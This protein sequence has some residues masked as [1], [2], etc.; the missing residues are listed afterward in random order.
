MQPLLTFR[1]TINS[2]M[3]KEG[4]ERGR[5]EKRKKG[6]GREVGKNGEGKGREEDGEGVKGDKG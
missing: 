5:G 2:R 6:E 1:R 3:G 4:T